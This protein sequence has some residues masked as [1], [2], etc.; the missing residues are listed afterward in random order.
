[1]TNTRRPF[2]GSFWMNHTLKG[3]Q[4]GSVNSLTLWLWERNVWCTR[5]SASQKAIIVFISVWTGHIFFGW[6][7][8]SVFHSYDTYFVVA[9]SLCSIPCNNAWQERG[10]ILL[11]IAAVCGML[12]IL[13]DSV[14]QEHACSLEH[15]LTTQATCQFHLWCVASQD[16]AAHPTRLP[17]LYCSQLSIKI[18]VPGILISNVNTNYVPDYTEPNPVRPY[19]QLYL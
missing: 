7:H 12:C 3:L 9:I 19:W 14:M 13:L 8:G 16:A 5:P 1:M 15:L 18:L 11:N 6:V 2:V 10:H 17:L 4:H